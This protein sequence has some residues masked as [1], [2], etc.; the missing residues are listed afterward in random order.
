M[1]DSGDDFEMITAAA[2]PDNFNADNDDNRPDRR[3]DNRGPEPSSITLS[4]IGDR[5]YAFTTLQRIGGIMIYD[6]T[7]PSNPSFV[8]YVNNRDFSEDPET[9][10]PLDLGPEGLLFIE[11]HNSPNQN[12]LVVVTNEVSGTTTIYSATQVPESSSIW[13]LLAFISFGCFGLKFNSRQ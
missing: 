1:F 10:N 12:P 6:V 9:G 4:K 11:A 8:D 13:G 3:S 5:T 7:D 2:F